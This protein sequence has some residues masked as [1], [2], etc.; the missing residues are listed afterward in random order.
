MHEF[1]FL[2]EVFALNVAG[3]QQVAQWSSKAKTFDGALFPAVPNAAGP[4]T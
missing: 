3:A 1:A 2:A 4:E